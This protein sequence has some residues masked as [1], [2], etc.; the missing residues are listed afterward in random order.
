MY[1]E[2]KDKVFIILI[3]YN[4]ANDTIECINSIKKISYSNYEIIVVDNCSTDNSV[5]ILEEFS[6]K[7]DFTLIKS[8]I[9]NGFSAGNNLGIKEAIKKDFDYILLLNNDTLV[10]SNF[11]E[12]LISGFKCSSRCG[13]TVSKIYYA[14]EHDLIW[15]DG[16]SLSLNTARTKHWHYHQKDTHEIKQPHKV[17]FATG[18]CMCLSKKVIEDVGLLDEDYFLYEEDA[19]YCCRILT[20]GY[21]IYYIPDSVIYHKV[22][23]STGELSPLSQYYAVRNK[24]LFIR[25]NY[26]GI[27]KFI[28]YFISTCMFIKRTLTGSLHV[29]YYLMALK[30]FLKKE[31]RK[32]DKI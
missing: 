8:H 17:S 14:K 19:D 20:S 4:G 29:K 9:N 3:N 7:V 32:T 27:D 22:S 24:Y 15:Y 1:S 16:G 11:L 6:R 26:H 28:S 30:S 21:D 18:C 10:S 5:S 12:K 31:T 23:S 25:K 13:V 2:D